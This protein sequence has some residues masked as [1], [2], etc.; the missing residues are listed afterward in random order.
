MQQAAGA[1]T[2]LQGLPRHAGSHEPEEV[3][4]LCFSLQCWEMSSTP[5]QNWHSESHRHRDDSGDDDADQPRDGDV[6]C[7]IYSGQD[8]KRVKARIR[9]LSKT[10]LLHTEG[11]F[12]ENFECENSNLKCKKEPTTPFYLKG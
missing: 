2:V 10:T 7:G 6:I 1:S 9:T 5:D 3:P 11:T 8:G 12:F 4:S